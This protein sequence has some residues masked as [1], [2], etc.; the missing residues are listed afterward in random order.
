MAKKRK[1]ARSAQYKPTKFLKEFGA[2][3]R[4]LRHKSGYSIN[5]MAVES[6]MSPSQ[7]IRLEKGTGAVTLGT[8]VRY[9]EILEKNPKDLFNFVYH[10]N[11]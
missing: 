10:L 7:I 3:C 8:I 1:K 2:H 6:G 5:R 11:L 9:A 4:A